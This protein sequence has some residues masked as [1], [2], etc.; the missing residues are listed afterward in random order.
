MRI[1]KREGQGSGVGLHWETLGVGVYALLQENGRG[2]D[3]RGCILMSCTRELLRNFP[4]G[5]GVRFVFS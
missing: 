5:R 2:V 1:D 4:V 3:G